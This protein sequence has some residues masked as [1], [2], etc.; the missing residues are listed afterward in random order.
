M[1]V[2]NH[3]RSDAKGVKLKKIIVL[4]L[5]SIFSNNCSKD[6][7]SGLERGWVWE[8]LL[9]PNNGD[10]KFRDLDGYVVLYKGTGTGE[11]LFLI[12]H[13]ILAISM[14]KIF[15]MENIRSPIRETVMILLMMNVH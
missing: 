2:S 4:L 6:P 12:Q 9:G 7:I 15:Q 1:Y 11:R 5:I 10:I 13:L 14:L 8:T 3:I